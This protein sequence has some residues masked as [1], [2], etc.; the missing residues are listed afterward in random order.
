MGE[1]AVQGRP[2]AGRSGGRPARER[3][4]GISHRGETG[5]VPVCSIISISGE[6]RGE[7]V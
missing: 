1:G 7:I 3:N 2:R 5:F 4:R 6:K